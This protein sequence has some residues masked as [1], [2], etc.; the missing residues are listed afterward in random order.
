MARATRRMQALFEMMRK[1]GLEFWCFHDRDIAPEGSTL[2]ES[3][4]NLDA[5]AE[6]AAKLQEGTQCGRRRL[7]GESAAHRVCGFVRRSF[8]GIQR[9]G[10]QSA[11]RDVR[12]FRWGIAQGP[13]RDARRFPSTRLYPVPGTTRTA[14][15]FGICPSLQGPFLSRRAQTLALR[16]ATFASL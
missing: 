8:H 5:V 7:Q 11:N 3:N 15:G 9:S 4:A 1:L 2:R 6:V 13:L 16:F 10:E 12:D 14:L